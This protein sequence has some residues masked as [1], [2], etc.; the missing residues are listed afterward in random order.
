MKKMEYDG[1]KPISKSEVEE[2]LKSSNPEIVSKTLVDL[3][4][5]LDDLKWVFKTLRGH[6]THSDTWVAGTAV[7]LLGEYARSKDSS[8]VDQVRGALVMV[9]HRE[10]LS[11]AIEDVIEDLDMMATKADR[12]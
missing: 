10:D 8:S 5:H 6:L 11:G 7:R 4:D 1:A 9:S 3:F 2:R 12:D